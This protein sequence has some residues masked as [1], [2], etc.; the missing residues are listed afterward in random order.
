MKISGDQIRAARGYLDWTIGDL[1]KAA[2]VS[3]STIRAIEKPVSAITG[4]LAATLQ[5]RSDAREQSIEKL[6]DALRKSGVTFLR[7]TAQGTG[8]RCRR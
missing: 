2:G 8:L 7:E 3:D 6:A 1:S 4:G 5:W